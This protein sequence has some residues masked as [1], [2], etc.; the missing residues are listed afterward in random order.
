MHVSTSRWSTVAT[1]RNI[2]SNADGSPSK[3]FFNFIGGMQ[4]FV[5]KLRSSMLAPYVNSYRRLTPDMACAS[6]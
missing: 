4:K 5:P 6:Q 2:F 1:G 3:E